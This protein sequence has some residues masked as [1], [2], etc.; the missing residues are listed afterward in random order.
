MASTTPSCPSCGAAASAGASGCARCGFV[1]FE[2]PARRSQSR[3]PARLLG[4]VL[5]LLAG[6]VALVLVLSRGSPPEPLAAVPA[7]RAE[8]RLE[9]QLGAGTNGMSGSVDCHGSISPGRATRCQFLYPNG[10]TQLM[11]VTLTAD[12]GLDIDVPFP[13]QRRP[14]N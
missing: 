7:A 5:L 2:L 10:D 1:F 13:A 11:L 8:P 9:H 4:A 6:G 14:G 12:G 3:P